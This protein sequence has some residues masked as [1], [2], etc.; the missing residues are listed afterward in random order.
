MT[1]HGARQVI[2]TAGGNWDTFLKWM[3]GQTVGGTPENPD[4]YDYDVA[5]FIRYK[6]NPANEPMEDFD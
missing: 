5:R 3:N 1:E 4:Y 6:C 2:E